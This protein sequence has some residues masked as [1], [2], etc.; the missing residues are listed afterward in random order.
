M[1]KFLLFASAVAVLFSSCSTDNT[2]DVIGAEAKMGT[3]TANAAYQQDGTRTHLEGEEV[4]WCKGDAIGVFAAG[5]PQVQ[6]G[7]I[8]GEDTASGTFAGNTNYLTE[9]KAVYAYYPYT[10]G[11]HIDG[12]EVELEIMA[13]QTFRGEGTFDAAQ[14]PA[15][16]AIAKL[17]DKSAITFDFKGAA[18]YLN[19]PVTGYGVLESL[20]LSLGDQV[21]A[22]VG[23]IDVA[24]V[25][26]PETENV[27]ETPYLVIEQGESTVTVNCG[28]IVLN[29]NTPVNILFVVPT[30][31]SFQDIEL[32]AKLQG[33]EKEVTLPRNIESA[34]AVTKRN[35][36][37]TINAD[38]KGNAWLF[39]PEGYFVIDDAVS[40]YGLEGNDLAALNFITYAYLAQYDTPAADSDDWK[41][42]F[43]K[44]G[45]DAW[46]LKALITAEEIDFE[47]FDAKDAFQTLGAYDTESKKY[48]EVTVYKNALT[49]Y[50]ENENAI[51][52]LYWGQNGIAVVGADPK[53][54]AVINGLTVLGNGITTSAALENLKFTNSFVIAEG[55]THAGFVAATSKVASVENVVLGAGNV[56]NALEVETEATDS[57]NGNLVGGIYG[58]YYASTKVGVTVEA[59]PEIV[60]PQG[61]TFSLRPSEDETDLPLIYNIGQMFG[62]VYAETD[63]VFDLDAYKVVSLDEKAAIYRVTSAANK[64]IEFK[65]ENVDATIDNV[66]SVN[67]N[68]ISEAGYTSIVLNGVSYWNGTMVAPDA[69]GKYFT[70]EELAYTMTNGGSVVLT[71]DVDM[72][73][74]EIVTNYNPTTKVASVSSSVKTP[75]KGQTPAEYNHFT[76]KNVNVKAKNTVAL[77]GQSSKLANIT[78]SN[79]VLNA[80]KAT[81]K[82][83]GLAAAG[84]A[85]N[86][87]VD[88][89][90][91]NLGEFGLKEDANVGGVFATA[92][93]ADLNN[94]EVTSYTVK[95]TGEEKISANGGVVVGML[96]INPDDTETLNTIKL[97]GE[98]ADYTSKGIGSQWGTANA[99]SNFAADATYAGKYPFGVV[100]VANAEFSKSGKLKAYLDASKVKSHN[101]RL[102]AGIVFADEMI[103]AAAAKAGFD[104]SKEY[105]YAFYINGGATIGNNACTVFGFN[106][107]E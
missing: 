53:N 97:T 84:S 102:S 92:T 66:V 34:K 40:A 10:R 59:L 5:T 15:Y 76:I 73:N 37:S 90:T 82:V 8:K 70:A 36:I 33:F 71:H 22:G 17:E 2:T 21:L 81:Q 4:F 55:N 47:A 48:P 1:K 72:Q 50:I 98:S 7:L 99:K 94:V 100:Y 78:V 14:A 64:V 88:G 79:V 104:T 51:E 75:A 20:T 91:I 45:E 25:D 83:G 89:L 44:L 26:N 106:K 58:V 52:S 42:V 56:L 61:T 11:T 3:I 31:V 13:E 35:V 12:T 46:M 19:F 54:P 68:P 80:T 85:E 24:G 105:K 39:Q 107:A 28:G 62:E 57:S 23:T 103:D 16:A 86:V 65:A 32:T 6:F 87:V 18:S 43:G 96:T 74:E 67:G 30:G 27:D 77:F 101:A 69:G 95:Y 60:A 38:A 63:V 49:W 41:T 9:G 29:P 93:P